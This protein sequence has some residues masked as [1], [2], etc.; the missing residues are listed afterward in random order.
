MLTTYPCPT[1]LR[2]ALLDHLFTLLHETLPGDPAA[3]R[4][5]ATRHLL[6]DL[7][8]E[9]LVDAL[10][11]ANEQLAGAVRHQ[12]AVDER[13]ASVYATFV[14]DWCQKNIDDSLV[15]NHS[16]QTRFVCPDMNHTRVVECR[17]AIS[18][19][20]CSYSHIKNRQIPPPPYLLQQ[21]RY[22]PRTKRALLI[23]SHRQA[24]R[25]KGSFA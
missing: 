6:P 14:K 20:R 17:K 7:E 5:S 8:G 1:S 11:D 10:K 16:Q 15:S 25:L 9:A 19:H 21:S 13:L 4:L 24:T 12:N 22:S 18:S 2:D 23:I 3:I